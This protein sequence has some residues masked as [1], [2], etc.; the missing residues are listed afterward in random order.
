MLPGQIGA[1]FNVRDDD[2]RAHGRHQRFVPIRFRALVFDEVARLEHFADVVKV[3]PHPHQQPA[4]A[5]SLGRRLG[6]RGNVDRVV[7]RTGCPP[8]QF[9]KQRMGHIA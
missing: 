2:Q 5:D 1:V 9:L 8:H 6:Q 4:G 3:R 7:V